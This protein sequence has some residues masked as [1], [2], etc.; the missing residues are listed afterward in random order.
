MSEKPRNNN[1]NIRIIND[2]G[3]EV[4]PRI[5]T[6]FEI[7]GAS[8]Q[9]YTTEQVLGGF[10]K[11][12][13]DGNRTDSLPAASDVIAALGG[14]S[15]IPVGYSYQL[16]IRNTEDTASD[17]VTLSATSYDIG[18]GDDDNLLILPHHQHN[19]LF[20]VTDP[21]TPVVEMYVDN[22]LDFLA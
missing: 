18:G 14:A 16:R 3:S 17:T 8:D 5:I 20:I 1:Q 15:N 10:I 19:Y 2:D 11:R 7:S 9:T 22:I 6:S 21:D 4:A 12:I 13:P